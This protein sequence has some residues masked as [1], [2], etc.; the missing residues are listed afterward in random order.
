[1]AQDDK[2][3]TMEEK[4]KGKAP[5][6][7]AVNGVDGKKEPKKDKDGKII[8]DDMLR[9]HVEGMLNP[10]QRLLKKRL[11]LT[12][13]GRTEELSEEDQQL[14]SNLDML[15]ERLQVRATPY[16][17]YDSFS[18][19]LLSGIE[20]RPLQRCTGT[21]QDFHQNLHIIHDRRA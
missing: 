21:D 20:H 6:S 13:V 16:S 7:D 18:H 9:V 10:G 2:K 3:P 14:K 17:G 15:V 12:D 19:L 4:G 11:W 1:M 5:A 8:E